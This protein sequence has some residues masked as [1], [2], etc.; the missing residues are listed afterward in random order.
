[1]KRQYTVS[2]WVSTLIPKSKWNTVHKKCISKHGGNDDC[3]NGICIALIS[4][5]FINILLVSILS[6]NQIEIMMG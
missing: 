5:P 6:A 3:Q 1:M 2:S 4:K